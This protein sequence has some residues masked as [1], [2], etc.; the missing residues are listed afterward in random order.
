MG[1]QQGVFVLAEGD[2]EWKLL[3]RGLGTRPIHCLSNDSQGLLAGTSAGL[4][5]SSNLEEWSSLVNEVGALGVYSLAFH[6]QQ[7]SVVLCGTS[8]ANL[9]LSLDH[10]QN[11]Q[12]LSAL[13]KHPGASHWS[14]PEAPYRPRLVRVFLHPRDLDVVCAAVHSGGFYLSG[15]I[16]QSWHERIDG[17]GRQIHD[18]CQHK[19][20]PG[21][22]YACGPVGF[23][24]SENLGEVWE[25]RTQGLAYLHSTCLTV[26]PEEP[27]VVF[28]ASHR[29][30]QGGG[31]L[32]RTSN[33]GARWEAC[34]GLPFRPDL[35]FTAVAISEQLLV[36]ATSAGE[37]FCS[38]DLGSSWSKI[39]SNLPSINCLH[40]I[41]A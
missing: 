27:N 33:A 39:R 1:T 25:N 5:R 6:P 4:A 20:L 12:E 40:L 2:E 9:W 10:G 35:R 37:V 21:R 26:H 13:R 24:L 30:A 29:G 31:T 17:L 38:R 23:Y 22:L 15:D 14:F 8:P 19:L 7:S 34:T 28:L 41:S 18:L 11:F 32:Y 36:V 3:G 16:G